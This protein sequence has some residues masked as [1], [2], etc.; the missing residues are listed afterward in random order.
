MS[1]PGSQVF[2]SPGKPL[3]DHRFGIRLQ[4]RDVHGGVD[5][6]RIILLVVLSLHP[7]SVLVE[8]DEGPLVS[9]SQAGPLDVKY[10]YVHLFLPLFCGVDSC[11]GSVVSAYWPENCGKSGNMSDMVVFVSIRAQCTLHINTWAAFHNFRATTIV[12]GWR[13]SLEP[14]TRWTYSDAGL[15]QEYTSCIMRCRASV[16]ARGSESLRNRRHRSMASKRAS[17]V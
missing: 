3:V 16:T 8:T 10:R 14:Y 4:R 2:D 11:S 12:Y 9:L 13:I 17:G 1:S 7:D 15:S 6:G 5:T